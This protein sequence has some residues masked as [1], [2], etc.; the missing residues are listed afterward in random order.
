M[1]LSNRLESLRLSKDFRPE[2]IC[3]AAHIPLLE[4]ERYESGESLPAFDHLLA[5]ADLFNV[6]LDYLADRSDVALRFSS[7]I[8]MLVSPEEQEILK[9]MRQDHPRGEE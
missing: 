5:L 8:V 2:E 6:S 7:E 9:Q 1:A 3:D 4:Y